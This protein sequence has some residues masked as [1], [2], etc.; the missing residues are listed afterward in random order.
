[1]YENLNM[2]RELFGLECTVPMKQLSIKVFFFGGGTGES[3]LHTDIKISL[4]V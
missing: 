3:D 4:F 2:E 1:M